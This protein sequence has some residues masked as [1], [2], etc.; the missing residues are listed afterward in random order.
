MGS[1]PDE[2]TAFFNGHN[3][4]SDNMALASTQPLTEMSTRNLPEGK[5]Q[6]TRKTDNL[7]AI[8]ELT[9]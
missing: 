4:S 7:T 3:P 8:H 9:V 5:G 1:F 6:P 2:V